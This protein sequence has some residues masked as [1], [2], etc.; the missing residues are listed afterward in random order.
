LIP[1]KRPP[2][3][4]NMYV[5]VELSGK[6]LPDRFVIPRSAVH[7]RHIYICTPENRLKIL[8][9]EPEFSMGDLT[10]L[11]NGVSEG[12]NLVLSDL[13]PAV[14]GMK[15]LPKQDLQIQIQVETAA[16]GEIR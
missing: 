5:E 10:V 6:V 15:L 4:T 14:D 13:V 16:S 3:A 2:L 1:G 9:I 7:D 12:E 11:I 8:K